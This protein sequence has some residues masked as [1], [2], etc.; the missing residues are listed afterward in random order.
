MGGYQ[1]PY[2]T[3]IDAFTGNGVVRIKDAEHIVDDYVWQH[4]DKHC[5]VITN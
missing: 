1:Y 4:G 3:E 5:P 2:V